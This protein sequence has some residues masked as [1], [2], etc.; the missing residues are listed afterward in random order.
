V[1]KG[2]EKFGA[3]DGELLMD[4]DLKRAKSLQ[5]RKKSGLQFGFL[6]RRPFYL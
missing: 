3:H 2:R 4:H 6:G 5:K 1:K